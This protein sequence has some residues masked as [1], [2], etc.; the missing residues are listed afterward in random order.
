MHKHIKNKFKKTHI[1]YFKLPRGTARV[2]KIK[3]EP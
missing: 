1:C 3:L 2:I